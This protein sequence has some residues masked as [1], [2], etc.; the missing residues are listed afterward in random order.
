[1]DV[2]SNPNDLLSLPRP[3]QSSISFTIASFNEAQLPH[4]QSII[5]VVRRPYPH[6]S[7]IKYRVVLSDTYDNADAMLVLPLP[8]NAVDENNHPILEGLKQYRGGKAYLV[9]GRLAH[10]LRDPQNRARLRAAV[11]PYHVILHAST[12]CNNR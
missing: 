7:A 8:K 4:C 10:E 11:H 6:L 1:M 2:T 9:V 12:K 3:P 5:H